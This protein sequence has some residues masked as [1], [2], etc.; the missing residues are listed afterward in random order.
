MIKD[1]IRFLAYPFLKI[2]FKVFP[3]NVAIKTIDETL[4]TL[5]NS[6]DS[7]IRFGDGEFKIIEGGSIYFQEYDA[8]LAERLLEIVNIESDSLL[9]GMPDVFNNISALTFKARVFWLTNLYIHKK[10]YRKLEGREFSNTFFS[11]P[12]MDYAV[13][14]DK[15]KFFEKMKLLWLKRDIVFIEGSTTRN[16]IGNS[17]YSGANSISR[18][19]C[20]SQNCFSIHDKVVDYVNKNISKNQLLLLSLGPAAKVIGYDLFMLGYRVIDIGHLDSE[21]EWCMMNAKRKIKINGKHTAELL[22][23]SVSGSDD[24]IYLSQI[25]CHIE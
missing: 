18:I 8:L 20:P 24:K 16:G 12:Y 13:K 14:T 1:I 19:V 11:R 17:L 10:S 15:K 9:I 7:L 23:K 5:L 2:Y 3:L 22:D 4:D 6:D 25:I 21:Y